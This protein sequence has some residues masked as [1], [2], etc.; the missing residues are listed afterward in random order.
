MR[1]LETLVL[2]A[3]ILAV[4]YAFTVTKPESNP[5]GNLKSTRDLTVIEDKGRVETTPSP[6]QLTEIPE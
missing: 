1:I 4:T 5:N 6:V 3:A 2:L